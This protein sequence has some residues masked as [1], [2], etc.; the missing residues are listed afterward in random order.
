MGQGHRAECSYSTVVLWGF[1]VF[2]KMHMYSGKK[3]EEKHI[4][5]F[6]SM[7][8]QTIIGGMVVVHWILRPFDT[9]HMDLFSTFS[10]SNLCLVSLHFS[11][12][13]YRADFRILSSLCKSNSSLNAGSA[14][15]VVT[16]SYLPFLW[17]QHIIV[18]LT[19]LILTIMKRNSHITFSTFSLCPVKYLLFPYIFWAVLNI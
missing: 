9:S 17:V 4:K 6:C 3:W 15:E 10:H 14:M 2:G 5:Q 12:Y 11:S 19:A 1:S 8:E 16:I 18:V 13:F 7:T